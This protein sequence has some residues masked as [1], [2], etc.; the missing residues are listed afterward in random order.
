MD[1]ERQL[2]Y[3]LG[4][5]RVHSELSGLIPRDLLTMHRIGLDMRLVALGLPGLCEEDQRGGIG[6][7]E[8]E[9]QVQED[10]G[11]WIPADGNG[12]RV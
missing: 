6:S 12:S 7:L 9:H 2:V 1:L 11:V 5:L 8:Q 10:E 3:L 4:E